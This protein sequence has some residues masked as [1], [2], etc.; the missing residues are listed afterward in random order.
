MQNTDSINVIVISGGK[1]PQS[2]QSQQQNDK[3]PPKDVT[4]IP[5][6]ST[7]KPPEQETQDQ[8]QKLGQDNGQGQ[9]QKQ[10]Q[11]HPPARGQG[12]PKV[13]GQPAGQEQVGGEEGAAAPPQK[14][15]AQLRA[16]RRAVQVELELPYS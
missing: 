14:S 1:S 8:G 16:E 3:L 2:Q 7:D 10:S 4:A 15:K 12:Q 5:P 11:G 9:P 6:K 13:Q